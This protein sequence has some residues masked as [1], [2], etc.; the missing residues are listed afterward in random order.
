MQLSR[1]Y[2]LEVSTF[3][4]AGRVHLVMVQLV[5]TTVEEQ[6]VLVTVMKVQVEVQPTL[7]QALL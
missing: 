1:L 7:E 5:D 3:M 4:L 6:Q 2:R